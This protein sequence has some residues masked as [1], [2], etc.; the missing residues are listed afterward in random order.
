[1]EIE[2]VFSN[3]THDHRCK[4]EK[5]KYMSETYNNMLVR[6]VQITSKQKECFETSQDTQ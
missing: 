1:M 6:Q 5:I 2:H 3:K 4:G